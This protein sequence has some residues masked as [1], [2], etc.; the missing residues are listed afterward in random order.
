M[1]R[2]LITGSKIFRAPD[3]IGSLL[4]VFSSLMANCEEFLIKQKLVQKGEFF[5]LSPGDNAAHFIAAWIMHAY[6]GL[7]PT[8]SH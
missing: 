3:G 2:M 8:L 4:I 5:S 1:P 7:V 6:V